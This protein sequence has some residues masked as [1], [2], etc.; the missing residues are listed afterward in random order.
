M[1]EKGF[2]LQSSDSSP[3]PTPRARSR[4]NNSMLS[5]TLCEPGQPCFSLNTTLFHF[6]Y[7][8]SQVS[9]ESIDTH[10]EMHRHTYAVE[11]FHRRCL[12]YYYSSIVHLLQKNQVHFFKAHTFYVFSSK[13]VPY[14][15]R[16][17]HISL[18]SSIGK[19]GQ[20]KRKHYHF[21]K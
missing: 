16:E 3:T 20:D 14:G 8:S 4:E 12:L 21:L 1:E 6:S 13:W 2:E 15:T 7:L 19:I 11:F 17:I 5:L 18:F 10:T 9:L